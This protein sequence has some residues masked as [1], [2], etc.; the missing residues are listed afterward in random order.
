MHFYT[1][2]IQNLYT[3]LNIYT[4]LYT[5][6]HYFYLFLHHLYIIYTT[7]IHYLHT[8]YFHKYVTCTGDLP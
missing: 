6:I 7:F 8:I 4:F 5:I 2:F 1:Q 3:L